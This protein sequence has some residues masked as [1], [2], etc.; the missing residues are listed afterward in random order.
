MIAKD[1]PIEEVLRLLC[2]LSLVSYGIEESKLAFFQREILQCYGFWHL[3]TLENLR[4]AGLLLLKPKTKAQK[5]DFQGLPYEWLRE[6]T[7]LVSREGK[8]LLGGVTDLFKKKTF[9]AI[10]IQLR[11]QGSTSNLGCS[12]D[13]RS[14]E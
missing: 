1:H 13:Q 6:K 12:I 8:S 10:G 2:L 11:H 4:K 9:L 3:Q 5:E 7:E 14:Q